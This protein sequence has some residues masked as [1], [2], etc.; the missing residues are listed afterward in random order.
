M[1]DEV[2]IN[3]IPEWE[4]KEAILQKIL[5]DS[6]GFYKQI[7]YV[8]NEK[9][10]C[11]PELTTYKM[12]SNEY[13]HVVERPTGMQHPVYDWADRPN[14]WVEGNADYQG[15]RIADLENDL[16]SLSKAQETLQKTAQAQ[17]STSG[18]N[19]KQM[20]L[21][22]VQTGQMMGQLAISVNQ[23]NAKLDQLLKQ[24]SST[25]GA[26]TADTNATADASTTP[27]KEVN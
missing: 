23:L 16:Q 3:Q 15:K 1:T 13:P 5:D 22:A 21:Q 20:Q 8:S 4:R 19:L 27:A 12:D 17:A 26:S 9:H 14:H 24:N 2:N 7:V 25:T 18:T 11:S 6:N 10:D